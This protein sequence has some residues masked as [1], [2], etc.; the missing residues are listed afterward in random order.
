[1]TFSCIFPSLCS[2]VLS[3][4]SIS[5]H[6]GQKLRP[7]SASATCHF[8]IFFVCVHSCFSSGSFYGSYFFI[9]FFVLVFVFCFFRCLL[10]T[11]QAPTSLLSVFP[12]INNPGLCSIKDDNRFPDSPLPPLI[13]APAFN[14]LLSLS[15]SLS[16]SLVVSPLQ[17]QGP[18]VKRRT[19]CT[20][21]MKHYTRGVKSGCRHAGPH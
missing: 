7:P 21:T 16:L 19:R 5:A 9:S 3:P 18:A 12:W 1:M 10:F 6:F 20:V 11:T 14:R 2:S 15:L 17:W 4:V 13:A 8:H